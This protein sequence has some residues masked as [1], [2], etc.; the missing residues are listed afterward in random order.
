[1]TVVSTESNSSEASWAEARKIAGLVS[2]ISA[3]FSTA[4]RFLRKDAEA[5]LPTMSRVSGYAV[6]RLLSSDSFKAP[7]YYAAVTF[8]PDVVTQSEYLSPR[9]LAEA[10]S[11]AEL[12]NLI[13]LLYLYRRIQKG[14]DE[15][16]WS[17]I[18][19]LIHTHAQMGGY[20]GLSMKNV[21]L[22]NGLLLGTI[23]YLSLGLFAGIEKKAFTQY[24]RNLKIQKK[25]FDLAEERKIWGCTHIEV[26]SILAQSLGLGGD[27]AKALT[28]GLLLVGIP[29][30]EIDTD[31]F[32]M[33]ISW[34]WI[35]S[36]LLSGNPPEITH[37]GDFYPLKAELAQLI[38][39]AYDLRTNGCAHPFYAKGKDDLSPAL[40]PVLFKGSEAHQE[41][42]PEEI[43][44]EVAKEL[45]D[46][47]LEVEEI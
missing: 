37:R 12:A 19:K 15:S 31:A 30:K 45:G 20:L 27:V 34:M 41:L 14:C 28:T 44:S 40:T 24:R 42:P 25:D 4:I 39:R 16:E 36:L 32:R 21:G 23:R 18:S 17:E 29:D 26:A 8:K 7:T 2:N 3:L 35:R 13:G 33:R 6:E 38:E 1:M 46:A 43:P 10:F 47:P 22:A 11:P 9:A 5:K